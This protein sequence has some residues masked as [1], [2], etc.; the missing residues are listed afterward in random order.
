MTIFYRSTWT[1]I[2]DTCNTVQIVTVVY[3]TTIIVYI[4][5]SHNF[6]NAN[7]RTNTTKF[8]G[9]FGAFHCEKGNEFNQEKSYFP[10]VEIVQNLL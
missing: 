9:L 10:W 2:Y 3:A 6:A 8:G 4:P 5:F 1:G 7:T